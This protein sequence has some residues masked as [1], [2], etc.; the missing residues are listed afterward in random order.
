MTGERLLRAAKYIDTDEFLL[1]YGDGVSDVDMKQL[2]AFHNSRRMT[3]GVVG[4]ITGIHPKSKYGLVVPDEEH[5]VSSFTEKPLLPDWTNGGFMVLQKEFME[6]CEKDQM[7]EDALINA[8]VDGKIAMYPHDGFWH[9]MDTDKDKEDLEKLWLD[10][11]RW[12]IW[13][14]T[15]GLNAA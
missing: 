5:V 13:D 3:R 6:Y 9:S 8:S 1:T 10:N 12:K 7:I 15:E 2:C 4:T 14:R 11:P